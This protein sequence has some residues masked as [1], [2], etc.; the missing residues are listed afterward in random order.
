MNWYQWKMLAQDSLD[1][2][3]NPFTYSYC[4]VERPLLSS[5][6]VQFIEYK[7]D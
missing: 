1:G 5:T 7:E 4:T 6:P 2:N 3:P